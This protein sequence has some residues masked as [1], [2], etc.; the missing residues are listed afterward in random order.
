M[1][2]YTFFEHTAD[3]AA[4]LRGSDLSDLIKS[5]AKAWMACALE[6]GSIGFTDSRSLEL[7]EDSP[8]ELL[9]G[10]VSE[11]NFLLN[12]R[13]WICREL[14]EVLDVKKDKGGFSLRAVIKGEPFDPDVHILNHE[15]KAVTFHQMDIREVNGGL[16]TI[17]VFDI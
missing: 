2:S 5:A 15:I 6:A 3:L 12:V 10:F 4:E 13:K 14:P 17:I 1:G 16:A 9:V 7:M 8:E 11:L